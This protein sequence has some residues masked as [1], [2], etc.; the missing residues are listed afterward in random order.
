[1]TA[2]RPQVAQSQVAQSQVERSQVARSLVAIDGTDG[3]GKS[4]FALALAGAIGA[5][6]RPAVVL[7]VDDFRVTAP[8]EGASAEDEAALYYDRY[9]DFAALDGALSTFLQEGHGDGAGAATDGAI[10]IVEGVLVLRA[11]LPLETPLIVLEVSPEVARARILSRDRAKGR[12][13]EE[14]GHR[15]DRRYFPAQARYRA[16]FDPLGRADVLLD[17]DDWARPRVL[18]RAD[19][20]LPPSALAGLDRLLPA[21]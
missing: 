17:N 4:H 12:T 19:G 10:A 1:V 8:F 7:R 15:I 16:D 3:S 2:P 20:R 21:G 6:G 11:N 9:Y 5:A 18:R 14:I 13:S